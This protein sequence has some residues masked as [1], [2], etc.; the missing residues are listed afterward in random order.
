MWKNDNTSN[1]ELVFNPEIDFT[2]LNASA[3]LSEQT[4]EQAKKTIY[5]KW[6]FGNSSKSSGLCK[7]KN[8]TTNSLI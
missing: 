8:Q 5:G 1:T 3:D 4:S 7:K 6:D 2:D